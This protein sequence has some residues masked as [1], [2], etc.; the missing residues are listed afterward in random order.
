M[1]LHG[2]DHLNEMAFLKL[3]ITRVMSLSCDIPQTPKAIKYLTLFHLILNIRM[4]S[5]P[6]VHA[7]PIFFFPR[8]KTFH[9]LSCEFSC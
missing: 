3:P 8:M 7:T 4:V 2:K 5:V 1:L 9:L 6:T